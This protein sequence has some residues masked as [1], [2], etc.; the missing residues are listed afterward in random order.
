MEFCLQNRVREL[1]NTIQTSF[2]NITITLKKLPP[3]TKFAFDGK[4]CIGKT[5]ETRL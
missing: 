1:D 3:N 4:D 5:Y 2:H